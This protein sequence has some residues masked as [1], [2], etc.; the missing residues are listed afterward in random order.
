MTQTVLIREPIGQQN[1]SSFFR[2][3]DEY[4]TENRPFRRRLNRNFVLNILKRKA[5]HRK[6]LI[7]L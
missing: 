4:K 5:I 1:R 7:D 6:H 2:A 3:N